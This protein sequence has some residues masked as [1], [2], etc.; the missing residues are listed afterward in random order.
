MLG[1]ADI[2]RYVAWA[3][4]LAV[5]LLAG[6]LL[7]APPFV[8]V[9]D[10]GDFSRLMR[11]AGFRYLDDQETYEER[12][13]HYA[14]QFYGYKSN[15]GS[16]YVSSQVL[17]LAVIGWLA[18]LFQSEV[19]DIRW[20]GA[21]YVLL[22]AA[23][24][25]LAVRH[26]PEVPGRR[27]LTALT[28]AAVGL[29]ILFVF[30][31]IGY[32]AYFHS[33]YGEPYAFCGML[34]AVAA[35][36]AAS[37]KDRPPAGLALAFFAA[38]FAVVTSKVQYA[39]LGLIFAA[40]GWRLFAHRADRRRRR[41]ALAGMAA[42]LAGT[43]IMLAVP[44]GLKTINLYQSVFYGILKDS[45]DLARDMRELGIPE[46]YAV[47]AGTNYFQKD[48]AIPQ[49]DPKLRREV[50]SRLSHA[51]IVIYY[52]RHPDRLIEKLEKAAGNGTQIRPYYLGNFDR[53]AGKPPRAL[54]AEFSA[55]SSW[56]ARHLPANLIFFAVC[57][58]C[59]FAVL[60]VWWL[61]SS[62]RR[63]RL[64]LEVMAVVALAGAFSLVI[65]VLGDGEAD[66]AKHLFMFN[67]CFD[68]MVVSAV[69]A[70]IYGLAYLAARR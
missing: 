34:L 50:L 9:A 52:L 66:L 46:R 13:F 12:Y 61:L 70:L 65:P 32:L 36:L 3:A 58:A 33:F 41:Q 22:M 24:V 7:F 43:M 42:I 54:A 57:F 15:W 67:V 49:D 31:D 59:Y 26:A 38:A 40:L 18:R 37:V 5:L 4:V 1:D 28:A 6:W 10:N 30:G 63:T 64:G 17:P 25:H 55:W 2:R 51:D 11:I 23:A 68:M 53:S 16:F 14:H 45:P 20:L 29:M 60:A 56:K 8:G 48:T 47:L 62:S 21:F 39:P 19:F 69:A 44:N 35:A 27:R